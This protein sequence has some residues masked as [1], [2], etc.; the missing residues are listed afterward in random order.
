M[1][2][3]VDHQTADVPGRTVVP[4]E[5]DRRRR[6]VRIGL[7]VL[8]LAL[9]AFPL[10]RGQI[11]SFN[12]VLQVFI[13][14]FM[15]IAMS[16]SW[17]ILGGFTGY[18][19][20]GHNVF[21]AI[22]GYFTGTLLVYYG[23]SPFV[24]VIFAG[25]LATAVALLVGLIALRA[26]GPAFIIATIALM[27]MTRLTFDNWDWIGSSN[28][29]SLPIPEFSQSIGKI[30]MYYG[31]LVAAVGAIAL[32]Y[33]VHASKF[34][35]GLRAIAQ[36]EIKAE[37]AGI[38]TR[39][40]KVLAFGVSAFFIAF[41]GAFWGYSLFYLRPS[42]FLTIAIA[43]D[44]VLMT[45]LGGKG[46]VAGPA[47]G[48]TLIVLVN[49]FAI[50]TFGSTPLNLTFTGVLLIIVLLFFPLG[51][52]GTLQSRAADRRARHLAAAAAPA[53]G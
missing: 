26:H 49:E 36:D 16:S 52:V 2:N 40:Y 1:S 17:N 47:V 23:L 28:G 29:L 30:P 25:I 5:G 14:M 11:S 38:D 43:A 8:V 37:V 3:Q 19:S 12:Y 10:M 4:Q 24:T 48:A 39:M 44:M 50:A 35:L 31:M 20:L 22:G 53:A 46:T 21:F 32:G 13:L 27:L 15:W 34:G 6:W 7:L 18:I 42:A 45:I 9:A 51:I 33:R 41:A